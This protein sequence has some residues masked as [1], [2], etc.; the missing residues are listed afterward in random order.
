M[1]WSWLAPAWF[2]VVVVVIGAW[3]FRRSPSSS[4]AIFKGIFSLATFVTGSGAA[5]AVRPFI[6]G[7]HG[8]N[9]WREQTLAELARAAR[10]HRPVAVAEALSAGTRRYD[11]VGRFGGEEF[12][13]TLSGVRSDEAERIAQ[14]PRHRV[15]D[16]VVSP[17]E[18]SR[19]VTPVQGVTASIGIAVW[20]PPPPTPRPWIT[21]TASPRDELLRS[22]DA[23]VHAAKNAGRDRMHQGSTISE[24]MDHRLSSE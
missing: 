13:V 10:A 6:V 9:T 24:P 21:L 1:P 7:D 15:S 18:G 17:S 19:G 20:Y 23:A 4:P 2:V 16:L 5:A 8:L 3:A 11:I 14:Q 22:A 12:V